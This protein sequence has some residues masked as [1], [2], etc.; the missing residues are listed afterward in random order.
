LGNDRETNHTV[1]LAETQRAEA[2][3]DVRR[4][5]KERV[6]IVRNE[7]PEGKERPETA[8]NEKAEE[9][10]RAESVKGGKTA[11]SRKK[12]WRI[13]LV[14][15]RPSPACVN[16]EPVEQHRLVDDETVH[17][18]SRGRTSP[19]SLLETRNEPL[20]P[21]CENHDCVWKSRLLEVEQ[22]ERLGIQGATVS[23]H[24]ERREDVV[25]KAV[26]WMGGKLRR[27]G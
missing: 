21:D 14:D 9:K 8:R 16:D 13:R 20:L 5:E 25:F 26:D 24:L 27:E 19:V 4:E 6:E 12:S 2:I 3:G 11:T 1:R 15:R 17:Q 7:R 10:D 18:V 22:S 23:L